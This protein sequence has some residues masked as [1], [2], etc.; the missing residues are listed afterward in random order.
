MRFVTA[1][2]SSLV[3]ASR[4]VAA[5]RTRD[6]VRDASHKYPHFIV[7]AET[8]R[9][10]HPRWFAALDSLQACGCAV[11]SGEA[12]FRRDSVI[13]ITEARNTAQGASQQVLWDVWRNQVRAVS[14]KDTTASRFVSMTLL[15]TLPIVLPTARTLGV[16][17]YM[18]R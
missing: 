1:G 11:V 4:I 5:L 13:M 8:L 9:F 14:G 17:E 16:W 15:V 18:G 2:A 6:S 3:V 12:L 10:K 7:L